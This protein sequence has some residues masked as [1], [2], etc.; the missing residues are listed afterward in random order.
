MGI[1]TSNSPEETEALGIAWAK[2]LPPKCIVGLRGDLGAGKTRL[3][4]GIAKGIG[5]EERIQSPTFALV[6]EHR[7]GTV[8]LF[9]LDLYR[10]ETREQIV[11]AG[12]ENYLVAPEGIV[13][14]EWI[15]RW[16]ADRNAKEMGAGGVFYRHV[17]IEQTDENERRIAYEDFGS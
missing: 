13:V 12:L 11:G 2:E 14:V 10:L 5:I 1:R 16:C 3:V 8:P 6:N 17:V 15:D 7:T 9:H 4:K